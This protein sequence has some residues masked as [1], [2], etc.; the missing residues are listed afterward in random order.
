VPQWNTWVARL[1]TIF[2]MG[3]I[4]ARREKYI[5]LNAYI[6][7][8]ADFEGDFAYLNG[9]AIYSKKISF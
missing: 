7:E 5:A 1:S 6:L 4:V 8:F 2:V 9:K 3:R